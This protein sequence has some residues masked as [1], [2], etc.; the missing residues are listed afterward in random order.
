MNMPS[1]YWEPDIE[2]TWEDEER[3]REAEDW[4]AENG[5]PYDED[6]PFN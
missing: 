1:R 5:I 6:L 4:I 3:I 2:E